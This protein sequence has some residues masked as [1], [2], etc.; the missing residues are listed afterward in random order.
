MF[1]S[2]GPRFARPHF[3]ISWPRAQTCLGLPSCLP[4]IQPP[5]WR[6]RT[7]S[8]P[9]KLLDSE[10][11]TDQASA[12]G[13]ERQT[14]SDDRNSHGEPLLGAPLSGAVSAAKR[15]KVLHW[16]KHAQADTLSELIPEFAT[17]A[18]A[19]GISERVQKQ[20]PRTPGVHQRCRTPTKPDIQ[21]RIVT[22][23]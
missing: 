2:D 4:P 15:R 11:G 20:N 10:G 5:P 23:T 16:L 14:I 7:R 22:V 8:R 17:L 1:E 13:Q 3:R 12:H 9:L 6:R 18:R 21:G 19:A